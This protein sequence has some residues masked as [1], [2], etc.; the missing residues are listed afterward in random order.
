MYKPRKLLQNDQ[1]RDQALLLPEIRNY[2]NCFS[3][4]CPPYYICTAVQNINY[5]ISGCMYF[6]SV[7]PIAESS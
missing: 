5:L 1:K 7:Y 4:I 6:D 2:R 3:L